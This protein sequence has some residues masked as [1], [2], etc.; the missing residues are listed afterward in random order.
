V[1]EH[2]NA[3]YKPKLEELVS[4]LLEIEG[5]VY[6]FDGLYTNLWSLRPYRDGWAIEECTGHI[7]VGV[8]VD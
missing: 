7:V 6:R 2:T 4:M 3:E 1:S 5:S 8:R